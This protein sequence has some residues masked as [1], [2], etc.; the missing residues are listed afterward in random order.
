M[1]HITNRPYS[2]LIN[3]LALHTV[4]GTANVNLVVKPQ[5]SN[6]MLGNPETTFDTTTGIITLPNRPCVLNAGIMYYEY[7]SPSPPYNYA[8]FQ[9]YDET[10]SQF[11]G[12][13]ARQRGYGHDYYYD[14]ESLSCDEQAIAIAQ[15]ITVSLKI[16]GVSL[17]N[18]LPLDGTGSQDVYAGKTR[19][20]IYEF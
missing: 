11:I 4:S 12:S 15:N 19:F 17:A 16:I 20:L 18:S 5:N 13:K 6:I 1:T 10:N 9:W 14:Y 8:D 7:G 3:I 2:A